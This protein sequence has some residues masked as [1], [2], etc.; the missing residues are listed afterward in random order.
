MHIRKKFGSCYGTTSAILTLHREEPTLD[1]ENE[2]P[3]EG[4]E[5]AGYVVQLSGR[6]VCGSEPLGADNCTVD[7]ADGC[8]GDIVA[9]CRVWTDRNDETEVPRIERR[10][11]RVGEGIVRRAP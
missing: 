4:L 2:P 3:D 11:L 10:T 9:T 1:P 5:V 8:A 6:E 7:R